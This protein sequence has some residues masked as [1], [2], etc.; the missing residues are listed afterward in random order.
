MSLMPEAEG[1]RTSKVTHGVLFL[2]SQYDLMWIGCQPSGLITF[3]AFMLF[4]AKESLHD[5]ATTLVRLVGG[6][7]TAELEDSLVSFSFSASP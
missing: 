4:S 2:S 7:A 5:D 1:R 3:G 6:A